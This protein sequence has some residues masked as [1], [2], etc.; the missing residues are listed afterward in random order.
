MALGL[1]L[2]LSL[3]SLERLS[4]EDASDKS[5]PAKF[6]LSNLL[7]GKN[8]INSVLTFDV[9]GD[10]I[11]DLFIANADGQDVI[12]IQSAEGAFRKLALSQKTAGV[13]RAAVTADLNRDGIPDLVLS[14]S[15]GTFVLLNDGN[16]HF[17]D[18]TPRA[19]AKLRVDDGAGAFLAAADVNGDGWIDLYEGGSAAA[20][21]QPGAKGRLWL[22][23]GKLIN[24]A[25]QFRDAVEDAG[26]G[27]ETRIVS[28]LFVDLDNDHD[29]DL[30][31]LGDNELKL[32]EN[33]G[34][35]HFHR[36]D[37]GLNNIAGRWHAI[38][39][40]DYNNDGKVDLFLSVADETSTAAMTRGA[41]LLRNDGK[42]HFTDVT[43]AAGLKNVSAGD[44]AWIDLDTDGLLD[45]VITGGATRLFHQNLAGRFT[46]IT[47]ASGF[48]L[49]AT[50]KPVV[51][52]LNGDGFD[53]LLFISRENLVGAIHGANGNHWLSVRLRA[54][55][56][57]ATL[58]TEVVVYLPDGLRIAKQVIYP[59]AGDAL[60]FGVGR[61]TRIEGVQVHWPSGKFTQLEDVP[62]DNYIG[63]V[64][65]TDASGGKNVQR[66]MPSVESL[67]NSAPQFYCR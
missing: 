57:A 44:A 61:R 59:N 63:F 31:L 43:D 40:G 19:M 13:T 65:P 20:P 21:D 27:G 14:R 8:R 18:A 54:R 51:A 2:A 11:P 24:G 29:Q 35:G 49:N 41:L 64:E 17:H 46:D 42:F 66:R 60:S 5:V 53:D 56:N 39:A 36:R 26:L 6:R 7:D 33:D 62:L 15:N 67:K 28:A 47:A 10:D 45:L 3:V 9:N 37:T 58:G 12:L 52:D 22:N 55:N 4:A 48:V 23:T 34:N 32:F 16:G 1:V 50:T 30:V 25:P 38:A